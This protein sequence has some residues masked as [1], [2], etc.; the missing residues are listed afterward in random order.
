MSIR[1]KTALTLALCAVLFCSCGTKEELFES[2]DSCFVPIPSDS[3]EF[4]LTHATEHLLLRD[5]SYEVSL[6]DIKGTEGGIVLNTT[7]ALSCPVA[8]TSYHW[9]I[10]GGLNGDT[11]SIKSGEET[12]EWF[13][14]SI[15]VYIDMSDGSVFYEDAKK[16]GQPCYY[17]IHL[18][19]N[20]GEEDFY[21]SALLAVRIDSQEFQTGN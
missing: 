14:R 12:Y 6:S 9:K 7:L 3:G 4:V 2:Y 10:T 18:W 15:N 8:C 21:D 11:A 13:T 16:S 5:T 1:Q 17:R 19:V 20:V